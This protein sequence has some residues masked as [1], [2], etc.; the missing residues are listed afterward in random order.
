MR[1]ERY[2]TVTGRVEDGGFRIRMIPAAHALGVHS[3]LLKTDRIRFHEDTIAVINIKLIVTRRA[4][5]DGNGSRDFDE[6]RI[7]IGL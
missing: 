2:R 3:V 1:G 5:L 7:I 6:T 4:S